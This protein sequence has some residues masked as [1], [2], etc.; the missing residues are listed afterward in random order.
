M[1]LKE[2]ESTMLEDG[3]HETE[4]RVRYKDTDRMGWSTMELSHLF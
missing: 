3:W 1:T 4:I 2:E